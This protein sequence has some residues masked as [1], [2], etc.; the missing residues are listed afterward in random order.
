MSEYRQNYYKNN[1]E[2]IYKNKAEYYQNNRE[3]IIAKNSLYKKEN[4]ESG[5]RYQKS[6]KGRFRDYKKGADNRKL[7]FK[8]SLK[9][10]EDNWNKN[11]FYCGDEIKGIGIDRV[12]N[13]IGYNQN[14]VVNCCGVCNIMKRTM[15]QEYFINQCLKIINHMGKVEIKIEKNE[16]TFIDGRTGQEMSA[17]EFNQ[18]HSGL[19]LGGLGSILSTGRV[20]EEEG[21][22]N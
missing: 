11:C 14:N 2:S 3:E 20:E 4:P 9:Y 8:L 18:K 16:H 13:D 21:K 10:F 12:D 7:E 15:T 22:N 19:N 5:Q 1:K 6:I 17:A